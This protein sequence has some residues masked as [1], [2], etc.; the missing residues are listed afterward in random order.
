MHA[1]VCI[2]QVPDTTEVKI[3]PERGT[4]I[5]EGVPSIINPFDTYAIEEALR[6]REKFG[7]K[8]TVITMGPSQALSALKEAIAMGAD[9]A[10]LLNDREFAGADTW[11]TAYTLSRA[12]KKIGEFDLIFCGRQAIDG[13][14]GQTG[15]GIATQLQISQLTYVCRVAS[16]DFDNK[17]IEVERLVEEGREVVKSTLPCLITVVKDINQPRYPTILGIRRSQKVQIPVWTSK[18]LDVNPDLIGL[19]GS[20][21]RV[22]KIST[23][24]PRAG[25]CQIIE[26]ESAEQQ[27]EILAEKLLAE[28]III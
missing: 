21:T 19:K 11:A 14:T 12:I 23:P 9:E 17:T 7:G 16:L 6:I 5:R 26:G 28:K 25:E 27:A 22:V 3:D 10:I 24:P 20:P 1:I 15:P 18:D 2:K 13:D 8:V 4:L